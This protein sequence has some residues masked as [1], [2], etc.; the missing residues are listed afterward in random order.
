M[1]KLTEY[2]QIGLYI[3]LRLCF[4]SFLPEIVKNVEIQ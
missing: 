3:E 1:N 2:M 4:V